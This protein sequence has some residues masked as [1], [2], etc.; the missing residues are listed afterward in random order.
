MFDERLN[1]LRLASMSNWVGAT[2]MS[3]LIKKYRNP[4]L[5]L[6]AT[7]DELLKIKGCDR[8]IFRL[9]PFFFVSRETFSII[10]M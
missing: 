10:K 2:L 3:G 1:W 4:R 5:A 6:Q 9:Q 8:I 7:Q